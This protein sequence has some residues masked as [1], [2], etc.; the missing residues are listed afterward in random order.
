MSNLFLLVASTAQNW[1]LL[2]IKES[3]IAFLGQLRLSYSSSMIFKFFLVLFLLVTLSLFCI[4]AV[5]DEMK[6]STNVMVDSTLHTGRGKLLPSDFQCGMCENLHRTRELVL[7]C[8]KAHNR[9]DTT[10]QQ[11]E[12]IT[13]ESPPQ[14][15]HICQQEFLNNQ[16]VRDHMAL[17]HGKTIE[18]LHAEDV[19]IR[20]TYTCELCSISFENV[21]VA[22]L[23]RREQH[24]I[25]CNEQM[26]TGVRV[27][28][29][30]NGSEIYDT[31]RN[32]A[33]FDR[34]SAFKHNY[35]C[36]CNQSFQKEDQAEICLAKHVGIKKIVCHKE[37]CGRKYRVRSELERHQKR[38][39]RGIPKGLTTICELCGRIV[40]Q[41]GV[42]GH[43]QWHKNGG[44]EG[45]RARKL[46]HHSRQPTKCDLCNKMYKGQYQLRKH[47]SIIH[48]REKKFSCPVCN[49]LF[50]YYQSADLCE[51]KH[52]GEKVVECDICDNKFYTKSQLIN[53]RYQ[54][55]LKV[56]DV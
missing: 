50:L 46:Q 6:T 15:C 34:K 24:L 52:G 8:L 16:S 54:T 53:H 48:N 38:M 43:M 26:L 27:I 42:R 10:A 4:F 21:Q 12:Q 41:S 40:G 44:A 7:K 56:D 20:R 11:F 13:S 5:L 1:N 33:Y 17:V 49:K 51:A 30:A 35:V 31:K 28:I 19:R 47:I 22:A 45:V 14:N 32:F 55:H 23:H 36:I 9:L 39:H 2:E 3:Q 29:N 25:H 37:G 18:I